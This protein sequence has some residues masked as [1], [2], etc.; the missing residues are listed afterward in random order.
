MPEGEA[1]AAGQAPMCIAAQHSKRVACSSFG[2][3]DS[4]LEVSFGVDDPALEIVYEPLLNVRLGKLEKGGAFGRAEERL[5]VSHAR[6]RD[7][8]AEVVPAR[9]AFAAAV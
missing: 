1:S 2:V 8:E 3:D 9:V 7:K 4:A 5:P 6:E